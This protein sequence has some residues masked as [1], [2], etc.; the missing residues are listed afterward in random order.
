MAAVNLKAKVR[1]QLG[2]ANARRDRKQGLVPAVVYGHGDASISVTV[3][4][5]EFNRILKS[6]SGVNT[7]ITLDIEGKKDTALARQINRHPT[8]PVITHV[9]FIRVNVN[10]AVEAEVT[11]HLEGESEGER[12]GGVLEQIQFSVT[13]M[14]KPADI[15]TGIT[16]NISEL[17]IGDQVTIGGLDL[18]DGVISE[19]DPETVIAVINVP[20]AEVETEEVE[21]EEG[22]EGAA[23]EGAE[24]APA[25]ESKDKE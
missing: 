8:R 16:F 6:E 18:P 10:E 14:A 23:A 1:T 3:D 22:A 12:D 20:K 21:G 9:D 7:L 13:V 11:L 4:A 5:L 17:K 19:I 2:S 15:P 25:A 24:G